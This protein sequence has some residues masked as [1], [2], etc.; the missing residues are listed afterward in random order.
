MSLPRTLRTAALVASISLLAPALAVEPMLGA[1]PAR[2]AAVDATLTPNPAYTGPAFQGWGTSLAWMAN[3]TGAYPA[4]VRDD[5]IDKVFGPDG[6]RLNI[7]RYNVGGGNASDVADYLRPGGAVPGWWNADAGFRDAQGPITSDYADR[8]RYLAAWTGEEASDYDFSAD[9]RQ[10]AWIDAIKRYVTTWEAF[11]NSPPYF[12]TES[13]YV[14]GGTDSSADQIRPDAVSK[15]ATYLTTVVQHVEQTEGISFSTIDP[16]NE[17][18]T[19]YWGTTLDGSGKPTGGGQEGA[20]ASPALQSQV[21]EALRSRLDQAG[22]TTQ[23]A[24]AGPDETNPGTFVSDWNGWSAGAKQAVSRLNVHTYSTDVRVQARDIAKSSGKPLWMSEVEGNWGGNSW[25]PSSIENGLGIA[26]QITS[27]LRELEPK[28][29]VL[30]QPVEDLYNMQNV[31][32]KNWGSVFVDFDCQADGTSVR[33][34]A[35]G[36]SSTRCGVQ[37][38]S[39]YNT[40]RNFTHY[41]APG[42]RIVPTSDAN[43]TSAIKGDG[44]GAVLVYT[45]TASSARTVDVDLSLFGTVG[46]GATVTPVT[47][48]ES[49]ATAPTQNALVAGAPVAVDSASRSATLTVPAKSVT[50]FVVSQ[51]SGVSSAP[52][53]LADGAHLR[54]VGDQSAKALTGTGA[55]VVISA[56]DGPDSAAD[57]TWTATRVAAG[58]GTGRDQYVL[59]LAD[60]RTLTA[61]GGNVQLSQQSAAQAAADPDSRWLADTTDGRTFSLLNAGQQLVLDVSG[62]S[63]AEGAP[64]GLWTAN[65][66]ENQ[67]FTL[68]PAGGVPAFPSADSD[69]LVAH[70][71]TLYYANCGASTTTS[72]AGASLGLYQ[73]RSDQPYGL[74]PLTGASWGYVTSDTSDPLAGGST[75]STTPAASLLYDDEPSGASLPDR[76]VAY[77]FP[78]P[79]GTYQVTFGAKLPEG[80]APR[81]VRLLAEGSSLGVITENGTTSERTFP[82]TVSDG[83]L[84]VSVHSLAD[85]TDGQDDPAV[86]YI[87]VKTQAQWTAA[88]L[89]QK[90]AATAVADPESYT[91]ASIQ[92]LDDARAVARALADSG[93]TDADAIQSAFQ[94]LA[95]AF[96]SLTRTIA[97]YTSFHPGQAWLDDGDSTIQAHGGQVV[98]SKDSGGRTIYY[99]YGE[100]RTNG[101]HS[102]PG[103]HVY[104]SYDLYNWTDRGVALRAMSSP[105]QFTDDPY[106]AGLYGDDSDDQRAAVYRDLG[107]VQTDPNVNPAILERPKVIYN[108]TTRKWVMWVHADGPSVTSNAQYAKANAGVAI[109]DSPYGPFRYLGSSRLDYAS[110]DDP[111]NRAPGNPGMAR[112]M[113]LFVDDDGT[114]YIIYSSEENKTMFISKLDA[115][116]TGLATDPA[117]AVE[118]RDYR[119]VFVG[120]SRESPAMFKFRGRYFLMTSGTSGWSPNPADYAS[121]TSILGADWTDQGNPFPWWAQSTSWNTQPTSIIPVDPIDGKFIYMGDRWNNGDDL[122]NAQLVWLPINLGESGSSFGIEVWDEWTLD[123]LGQWAAWDVTDAPT[124]LHLG[125]TPAAA[126]VTV[127]QN[128]VDTV[129]PVTWSVSGDV[130]VPG[131]VTITGTLPDFG[132]RTFTR[133]VPVLPAGVRYLVNAGGQQTADWTALVTAARAAGPVYNQA[134]D[135]AFAA[136]PQTGKGWGYLG[137]STAAVGDDSGDMFSTLRYATGG[138]ELSY[139]FDGLAPGDYT[140]Y[141]GY[142]DPWPWDDRGANVTIDGAVVEHDRGYAATDQVATYTGAVVGRDGKL[143]FGLSPTRSHDVQLSWLIVSDADAVDSPSPTLSLSTVRVTAGGSVEVAGAG[144]APGSTVRFELH[145]D[146]V[147]LGAATAS[148]S[149]AVSL[150]AVVPADTP[151]GTHHVVAILPNG[152]QVSA[153]LVVA[154]AAASVAATGAELAATGGGIGYGPLLVAAALVLVGGLLLLVRRRRWWSDDARRPRARRDG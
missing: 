132:G 151:A 145:S 96:A 85:R 131:M 104:S 71:F 150:R 107:T 50:T 118:G 57:Q 44:S 91:D 149:G 49:P 60:G 110:P 88:L 134:P 130:N 137:D 127:R 76:E 64:V 32:K 40:I 121:S 83:R 136:D 129:R 70:D 37:V 100:D 5:L 114:A 20:H 86:S 19:N 142:Y 92:A 10:R 109:S 58:D 59:S 65:N 66:G 7:A 36:D 123:Q 43:T 98:T 1:A 45:N 119:R 24:V 23:A 63:T 101:Y 77:S 75:G 22:T 80:W 52:P 140:V 35:D 6:L 94:A 89:R 95:T 78:V 113:N 13:G 39:K 90:L 152:A 3:A 103:V 46:A 79:N 111:T 102:S 28:A 8:D 135:Q 128:G 106:F 42:D 56:H 68:E 38:N 9:P 33:R 2:A 87:I 148:A 97:P 146:P 47:T 133:T 26:G 29:W 73:S 25:N 72:V 14:S 21:L 117:H 112:D 4:A 125:Q 147:L 31:E 74:D 138:S 18:N 55:S 105:D 81:D 61:D 120:W 82:V 93:S 115:D 139:E 122:A 153:E 116:Y 48:T 154:S 12:M 84:D 144:F 41:I 67:A 124:A 11:S 27:D 16:L 62:Q 54:L 53:G 15:F 126:S 143:T 17:P 30:W 34:V 99:L 51:V 108:A 141:A 69:A